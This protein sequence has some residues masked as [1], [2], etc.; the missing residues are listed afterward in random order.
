[1]LLGI[2][3][4]N[5]DLPLCVFL[6]DASETNCSGFRGAIG[7]RKPDGFPHA[8]HLREEFAI[9]PLLKSAEGRK[10]GRRDDAPMG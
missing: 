2:L 1:M 5:L 6:L 9:S 7:W 10:S 4:V 3:A 8:R